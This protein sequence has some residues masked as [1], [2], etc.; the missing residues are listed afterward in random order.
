MG[1]PRRLVDARTLT[2]AESITGRISSIARSVVGDLREL[3]VLAK[4]RLR[5]AGGRAFFGVWWKAAR[6]RRHCA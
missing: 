2:L 5:E 1:A 4:T 3:R 6:H